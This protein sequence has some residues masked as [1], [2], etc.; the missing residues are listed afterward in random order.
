MLA[1]SPF[2]RALAVSASFALFAGTA[3][4]DDVHVTVNGVQRVPA[5]VAPA[6]DAIPQPAAPCETEC[7]VLSHLSLHG[8]V[9][10]TMSF[11]LHGA[12]RAKEDTKIPLFGPPGQVHL[13]DV[14]ID[15]A[16]ANLMFDADHY[17]LF[18]SARAF[19]VRGKISLGSDWMLTVPGPLVALDATLTKGKLIEGDK[20]SGILAAVLH[21]DPMIEG[22]ENGAD[23]AKAKV[24]PVFRVSRALRVGR[25][26]T[27]VYRVVASQGTDLGV[28]RFPL[29]HGEKV[30]DA[31]G[32]TGWS[33]EGSDLLLPTTGKEADITIS[34]TL[35]N[36]KAFT[37][38]DRA[39]Y[40]WLLVEADPE[41]R[42]A[43]SGEGKLVE[44]SQ[45][46]IPPT[47]PGAR[48]Y[49][50]QRGQ[51]LDVESR[52]L[53]RG[54]V[55]A[56]VARSH[57]RFVAITGAGELLSDE[58]ITYENNGLDH[59]SLTPAG[60]AV[61]LSNDGAPQRILHDD[62]HSKDVLVP[63]ATG[64]HRMRV[65]TLSNVRIWP[66]AG[67]LSIPP[68]TYPLSTS[69]VETTV[70]LPDEVHPIAVFGGD[71]VRWGFGRG[72]LVGVALGIALAC[73]GF[74]TRKTRAIGAAATAGLWFVS[75]EGF[76]IAASV[77]AV[78]G[79]IFLA[80]R[81]LRSTKLLVASGFV[82]SAGM[83]V[84][85]AILS[86]GG[87][88][89]RAR[90]MLI[91][92]LTLPSPESSGAYA[93]SSNGTPGDI[94]PVSLSF[95]TSER[96]VLSSRQVVSQERPFVPRVVYVT[97]TLI[98]FLHLVWLALVG[99]LVF[100]HRDKL[101]ILKAKLIERLARRPEVIPE[102]PVVAT[103]TAAAP[104]APPF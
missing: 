10:G 80:S 1:R 60:K 102:A 51:K 25:E 72:D 5:E 9:D 44:T 70:G 75:R 20:Q 30:Q 28:I 22:V 98:G 7:F 81:F 62:E 19:T 38:D 31:Q 61:Y 58:V 11:E 13:S 49:L 86:D 43:T 92:K 29:K 87:A 14:T 12:V 54:D 63:V 64:S 82:V 35:T 59:L 93:R 6:K 50:L 48:V 34:G 95:P 76:V 77:L 47:M 15:G 17:F 85:R 41:H 69:T 96:Y 26:T 4:A 79:L 68:S 8:A 100:A 66:L 52:S 32:S 84:A 3:A 27:F 53:V 78:V 73:F 57:N 37:P 89:E 2:R 88:N 104:E 74:R 21:F 97:S 83:L 65:Q 39:A 24:P 67:A 94:T 18:T 71:N 46:P 55:L 91:E 36:V 103:A 56:A 40:E 42:V 23:A 99:L 101:A 33:V 90:D 16:R 45:S